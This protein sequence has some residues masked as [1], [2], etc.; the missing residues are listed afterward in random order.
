MTELP[1]PRYLRLSNW[2]LA[3]PPLA[4]AVLFLVTLRHR[5]WN[6]PWFVYSAYYVLFAM[7]TAYVGVRISSLADGPPL[8][9]WIREN[10]AGLVTTAIVSA[11]VFLAVAPAYRVLADEAN[12]VG[13][14]KNLFFYRTANLAVSGKWYFESYWN[15]NEATDRRPALFPFFVSLL[16]VVRGYHPENAFHVNAIL[17]VLFV[18]SSYRLAK[19]LGGEVFGIAAAILVAASPTTLVSARSAGF[20][21]FATFLLLVIVHSFYDYVTQ[22]SPR[23]LAILTLDLCLLAHVRYEGGA[24]LGVTVLLLF[25]FRA[26]RWAHLR[27]FGLLYSVVPLFLLPRYWQA[28]AKADDAE[29]PLTAKLFGVSH[30]VQ[31]AWQYLRLALRPLAVAEAHSPLIVILGLAGCALLSAQWVVCLRKKALSWPE[32][33]FAIF[34]AVALGAQSVLYFSYGQ[35]EPQQ[36]ASARLFIWLDTFLAF[37]A[38]WLL[39]QLGHRIA[40]SATH[41]GRA[42]A[43]AAVLAS[44]VLFATN[45]PAAIDA[46]FIHELI[47]T[48]QAAATWRFFDKLGDKGILILSD[49]PGLYTIMDYGS[50]DITLAD[51]DR[52][53]LYEL[54]RHLYRDIYLVQEVDLATSKPLPAFDAWPD[55]EKETVFEFQ[56]TDSTSVRIARV[57]K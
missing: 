44:A 46:R 8:R 16:H 25:S 3:A 15:L 51:A 18:F 45:L 12:L 38:A 35:G 40:S 9:V 20:D 39:T 19:R 50:V 1:A 41:R 52:S 57:K 29:Q 37:A 53:P 24:L 2:L 31:N 11:V 14:S 17:F 26:V 10:A 34:V 5:D 48:R 33:Q 47:L 13:V 21:F 56:N 55:V 6:E 30:F 28:I 43:L 22:P 7:V 49:R 54:S 42:G 23:R 36:P 4:A 27:G 32:A